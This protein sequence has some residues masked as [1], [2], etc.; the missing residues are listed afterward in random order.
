[1][2]VGKTTPNLSFFPYWRVIGYFGIFVTSLGWTYYATSAG[3]SISR[4][5]NMFESNAP[6]VL[7]YLVIHIVGSFLISFRMKKRKML[8]KS[9][10]VM[11]LLSGAV[12]TLLYMVWYY[13][14]FRP[15]IV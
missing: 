5:T 15:I 1:M 10:Y 14:Q 8:T 11:L 6:L 7:V 2:A 3:V 13:V 12:I 9:Q 4:G